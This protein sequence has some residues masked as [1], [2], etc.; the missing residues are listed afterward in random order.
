MVARCRL[1]CRGRERGGIEVIAE[2]AGMEYRS[3][4]NA[5]WRAVTL[6][7]ASSLLHLSSD[8]RDFAGD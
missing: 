3:A 1:D 7:W 2:N 4:R 5:H 8:N 6:A